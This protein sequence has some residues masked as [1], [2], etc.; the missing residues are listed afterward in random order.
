M[1][2]TNIAAIM[3]SH[4]MCLSLIALS[5]G[6]Y[7]HA[8]WELLLIVLSVM[9]YI[10]SVLSYVSPKFSHHVWYKFG[11]WVLKYS[12]EKIEYENDNL[13]KYIKYRYL[14]LVFSFAFILPE[15]LIIIF[16]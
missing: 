13:K 12:G 11:E 1:K 14:F 16:D 10:L 5:V 3:I 6:L 7:N 4:I 9:F 15:I 8:D 2:K